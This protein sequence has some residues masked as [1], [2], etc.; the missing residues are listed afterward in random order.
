MGAL[1]CDSPCIAGIVPR[2]QCDH[3]DFDVFS[4]LRQQGTLRFL[5]VDFSP[6]GE[7][8][9]TVWMVA[10]RSAEGRNRRACLTLNASLY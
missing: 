10:I 8:S 6:A 4:S 5:V 7:K 9:T 1:L 3:F 2:R